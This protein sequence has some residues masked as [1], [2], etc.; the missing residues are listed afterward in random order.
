VVFAGAFFEGEK[1]EQDRQDKNV[2]DRQDETCK[3]E[4]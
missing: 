2:Q 4:I 3:E 1:W